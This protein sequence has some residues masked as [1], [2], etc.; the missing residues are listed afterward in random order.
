MDINIPYSY[1]ELDVDKWVILAN[2]VKARNNSPAVVITQYEYSIG[3]N[4]FVPSSWDVYVL[5]KETNVYE[6]VK[7]IMAR[8]EGKI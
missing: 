1:E 6:Q 5:N 8:K 7:D 4:K 3:A 2:D